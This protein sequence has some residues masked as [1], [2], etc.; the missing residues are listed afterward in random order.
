MKPFSPEL[1]KRYDADARRATTEFVERQGW[2]VREH[3]DKY[4]H[5]LVATRAELTLLIECEVKAVWE[6]GV[7]PYDSVQLPERKRKFFDHNAVFFVWCKDLSDA[8]Y[9]W[10][11]DIDDLEPVEVPNKYIKSGERFFQIPMNLT[12]LVSNAP[13]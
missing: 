12:K 4:A 1:F 6:N 3:P 11:K 10:A 7:F 9:F 5:D 13:V 2:E 8:V